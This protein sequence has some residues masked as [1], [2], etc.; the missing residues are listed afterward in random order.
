MSSFDKGIKF[1]LNIIILTEYYAYFLLLFYF[2]LQK[3]SSRPKREFIASDV[4]IAYIYDT[5]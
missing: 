1:F 2:L 4:A 3:E 5:K